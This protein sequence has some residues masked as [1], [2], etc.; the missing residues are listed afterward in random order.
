MLPDEAEGQGKWNDR[1]DDDHNGRVQYFK[2]EDDEQ[3]SRHQDH[4]ESNGVGDDGDAVHL[5]DADGDLVA[6]EQAGEEE[7]GAVE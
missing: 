2:T 1:R 3:K 5:V 6:S 7:Q 4:S